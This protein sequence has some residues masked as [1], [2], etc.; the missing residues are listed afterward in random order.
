MLYYSAFQLYI[1]ID[2]FLEGSCS[3]RKIRRKSWWSTTTVLPL[4]SVGMSVF[5]CSYSQGVQNY[6]DSLLECFRPM[7]PEVNCH[8]ILNTWKKYHVKES[9]VGGL[10]RLLQ[11]HLWRH[12]DLERR[13]KTKRSLVNCCLLGNKYFSHL[14]I[15]YV[16]YQVITKPCFSSTIVKLPTDCMATIT[17]LWSGNV[18]E[19]FFPL[20]H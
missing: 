15:H 10:W 18:L 6:T 2:I 19:I 12:I 1:Y 20:I 13:A 8:V 5:G 3:N 7:R 9:S 17:T 11:T 14:I 4:L 16:I